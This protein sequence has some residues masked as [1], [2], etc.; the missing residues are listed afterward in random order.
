MYESCQVYCTK[1][2]FLLVWAKVFPAGIGAGALF[3]IALI[4]GFGLKMI[5]L[6]QEQVKSNPA[7]PEN[8]LKIIA[9]VHFLFHFLILLS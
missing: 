4:I 5:R 6:L 9:N 2:T 8:Y 7:N 1:L 3:W